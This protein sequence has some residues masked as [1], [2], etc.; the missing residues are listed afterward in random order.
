MVP[1]EAVVRLWL[2]SVSCPLLGCCLLPAAVH[3]RVGARYWLVG[4]WWWLF[5]VG[6]EL[7][8]PGKRQAGCELLDVS[9]HQVDI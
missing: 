3:L 1:E 7:L 6:C 2:L 9:H 5:A 8:A 4:T